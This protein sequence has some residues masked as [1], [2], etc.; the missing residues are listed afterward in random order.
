MIINR[1]SELM[2]KLQLP[3]QIGTSYP[4]ELSGG[5]QQRVG[6]ARALAAD[7]DILLMDEPFG[8]LDPITR[9]SV[10]ALF[11]KLDEIRKKTIVLVTHDIQEAF[12]LGDRICLMDKGMMMQTGAPAE[13]VLNPANSF[14]QQFFDQQRFQLELL[15]IRIRDV[16]DQLPVAEVEYDHILSLDNHLWDA[17]EI[18]ARENKNLYIQSEDGPMVKEISFLIIQNILH[19]IKSSQRNA[20]SGNPVAV[21]DAAIR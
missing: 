6:L 13:L 20:G 21:Y 18:I 16:W 19:H 3:S 14:V 5:Q 10:R 9:V 8:A 4:H 2:E 7:P 1:V 15:S 11:G 17:M 12:E